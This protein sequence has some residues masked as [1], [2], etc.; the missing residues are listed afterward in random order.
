MKNVDIPGIVD[1]GHKRHK[2]SICGRV[3]F[4][5]FLTPISTTW[6]KKHQVETRYGNGCWSCVD[7]PD[8]QQKAIN[9][10]IY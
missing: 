7:N 8:C 6:G 10:T 5:K 4:K 1:N 3:R 2:C 9:F